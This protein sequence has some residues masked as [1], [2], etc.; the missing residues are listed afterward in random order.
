MMHIYIIRIN[1]LPNLGLNEGGGRWG[2]TD[3]EREYYN[4]IGKN[5]QDRG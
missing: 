2:Q 3:K 5:G 1:K 4:Y